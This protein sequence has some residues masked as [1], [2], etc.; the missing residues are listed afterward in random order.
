MITWIVFF[1]GIFI[2]AMIGVFAVGMSLAAS[3]ADEIAKRNL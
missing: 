1:I 2:G 3:Q